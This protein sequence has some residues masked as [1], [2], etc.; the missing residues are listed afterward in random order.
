MP[1]PNLDGPKEEDI[2]YLN[3]TPKGERSPYAWIAAHW[4]EM[5]FRREIQ[6][7]LMMRRLATM[8]YQGFRFCGL[9]E[10]AATGIDEGADAEEDVDETEEGEGSFFYDCGRVWERD[11]AR[12]ANGVDGGGDHPE[13]D[14]QGDGDGD[15]HPEH[16]LF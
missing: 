10:T 4:D 15:V 11:A 13:K 5:R 8:Q 16:A 9:S 3:F 12:E 2:F 7:L 1:P 6:V 14:K